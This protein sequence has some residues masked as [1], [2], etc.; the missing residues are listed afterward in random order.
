[1]TKKPRIYN[2]E[3]IVSSINRVGKIGHP[4]AM[5]LNHYFIPYPKMNTK[6]IKDLNIRPKTIKRLEENISP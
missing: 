6:W 5:K 3:R 1:M 2:R 4:H